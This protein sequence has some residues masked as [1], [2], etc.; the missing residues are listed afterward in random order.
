LP[1]AFGVTS[2]I[3]L[4]NSSKLVA[5][6]AFGALV[7]FLMPPARLLLLRWG[8]GMEGL[9][10]LLILEGMVLVTRA[11]SPLRA[12]SWFRPSQAEEPGIGMRLVTRSRRSRSRSWP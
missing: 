8:L 5:L 9:T 7:L 10:T 6:A 12:T 1:A 11:L 4:P 2:L 3:E